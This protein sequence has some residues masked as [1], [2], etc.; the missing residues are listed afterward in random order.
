MF[1]FSILGK[2]VGLYRTVGLSNHIP[3]QYALNGETFSLYK[4][5]EIHIIW[6]LSPMYKKTR[7]LF[8][9][10]WLNI[11]SAPNTQKLTYETEN[12]QNDLHVTGSAPDYIHVT[13]Y[14]K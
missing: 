4:H 12:R 1:I 10:R 8:P 13:V 9:K 14:I 7:I 3:D 6:S 11:D 5:H 2:S